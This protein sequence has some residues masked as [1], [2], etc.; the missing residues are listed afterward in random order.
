M[1]A[2]CKQIQ[3]SR[4]RGIAIIAALLALAM[5]TLIALSMTFV[6]ST[7]VLIN[8]NNKKRLLQLYAAESA[9]EEA[10]LRIR[11]LLELNQLSLTD[12]NRTVYL[13]PSLSI[14]PTSGDEVTNPYFDSSAE[15]TQVTSILLS[16]LESLKFTWVKVWPK[17]ELRAGYSLD[18]AVL[19][20]DPAN[21]GFSK[22]QSPAKA[23]QYVNSGNHLNSYLGSPVFLCTAL[24]K[25]PSGLRQMVTT[26]ITRIPCPPLRAAFFSKGSVEIL[27]SAVSLDGN[28]PSDLTAPSLNGLESQSDVSGDTSLIRGSPM[29]IRAFSPNSYEM[30]SLIKMFQPPVSRQVESLNLN[31][32]KAV[33][34]DYVATGVM[35]GSLPANGNLSQAVYVGGPLTLTNSSGQG[36][37]VVNGDLTIEGEF[38][39][40]GLLIVNGRVSF[41][42]SESGIQIT[43]AVLVSALSGNPPSLLEGNIHLVYDSFV[44]RRQFD[45]LPYT[46]IAFKDF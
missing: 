45:S 1:N 10:R 38:I 25:E 20:T 26:E 37:L 34:G 15:S 5:L 32:S 42:G 39:Y 43:G 22:T 27:G 8:D 14:D 46:R 23:T 35:L 6:S 17:T 31:I 4:T 13:V 40:Q 7:E 24:A 30:G 18:D 9:C 16:D 19:T 2:G 3:L 11:S 41:N 28:D 12:L 33:G 29:A 44:I 36:I 21:F